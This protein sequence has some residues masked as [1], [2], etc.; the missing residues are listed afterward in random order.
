M[1][2]TLKNKKF[3]LV[4]VLFLSNIYFQKS[5]IVGYKGIGYYILD[6]LFSLCYIDS[7]YRIIE[8]LLFKKDKKQDITNYYI[9]LLVVTIIAQLPMMT[10]NFMYGDDLWGFQKAFVGN[11]NSGIAL[12]RPLIGYVQQ[13][14]NNLSF[15]NLYS[16]RIINVFV[17][18][19][20]S[21]II[22]KF[23]YEQKKNKELALI[24]AVFMC[25]SCSAIDCVAYASI[26]PLV[27]AI[28]LSALA[29]VLYV[30]GISEKKYTFF[31]EAFVCLIGAF[32]FYQVGTAIFIILFSIFALQSENYKDEK[33]KC[34][35]TIGN[36]LFYALTTL[37]YL[38]FAKLVQ[39]LTGVAQGQTARSEII[40]SF[41]QIRG[42]GAY[43]FETVIP[44]TCNRIIANFG[45]RNLFAEN[46]LFY[47]NTFTNKNMVILQILV[48]AVV[49]G[50][51]IYWSIKKKSIITFLN[52]VVLFPVSFWVFLVL[53]ESPYL[54]YY[55]V[56]IIFYFTI[57]V[58]DIISIIFMRVKSNR[59]I[60]VF[61]ITILVA[62]NAN[63]YA[64]TSWVNY[65][66]DAYEYIANSITAE[67]NNEEKQSIVVYGSIGP[68]TGGH[69]YVIF[70]V[71]NVLTELG[72]NSEEYEIIQ[73]DNEYYISI[74]NDNDAQI[75]KDIIGEQRFENLTQYYI[76]DDMYNR[77]LFGGW[78][79]EDAYDEIH[80][81]FREAG[82]LLEDYD[83][84]III[85]MKGFNVRNI[86]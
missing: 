20:F 39:H 33:K 27:Y 70:L 63:I 76:H 68:Y 81:C 67:I 77:W 37:T 10:Q 23:I 44:Q 52:G 42:K 60:I 72:K 28:L 62:I 19:L 26:F 31:A 29:T 18:Y 56:C 22:F 46:N 21:C 86:F 59:E 43:F 12:S 7:I 82:L 49:F 66:R 78:M 17:I 57:C 54:T 8:F 80:K 48:I 83:S 45:G 25:A 24:I 50:D 1:R 71:Q 74:F 85:D 30:R 13:F 40:S 55:A 58:C 14:V 2:E 75:M 51:I 4:I 11:L 15:D 79:P 41:A 61:A 65:N 64:E 35:I 47:I 36:Y 32:C 5:I 16:F 9:I 73:T 53:P 3:I 6:C 34:L 84:S 38:G 69:D